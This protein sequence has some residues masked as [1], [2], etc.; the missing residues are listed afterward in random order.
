MPDLRK[1]RKSL[2]ESVLKTISPRIVCVVFGEVPVCD[3][4]KGIYGLVDTTIKIT[5][6]LLI[7]PNLL[8]VII[9]FDEMLKPSAP[10]FIR[11]FFS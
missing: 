5:S 10:G 2:E 1:I 11:R 9:P 6:G 3:F 8:L 4:H 7:G